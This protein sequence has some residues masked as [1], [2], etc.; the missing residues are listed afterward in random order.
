MQNHNQTLNDAS[1]IYHPGDTVTVST[2]FVIWTG[3]VDKTKVISY[4]KD[5]ST[6]VDVTNVVYK[7][8]SSTVRSM[9]DY[10]YKKNSSTVV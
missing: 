10:K 3:S 8:S 5:S 1:G 6:V 2:D 9:A 4:K 7:N